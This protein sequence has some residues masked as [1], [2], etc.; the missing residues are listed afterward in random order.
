MKM[1]ERVGKIWDS[2]T[3]IFTRR[4]KMEEFTR[5]QVEE[6]VREAVE[7]TEKS[8]G[9][10][11]KRMKAENEDMQASMEAERVRLDAE[12]TR[13]AEER[14]ALEDRLAG[15]ERELAEKRAK[16]G[17]LSVREEIRHQ[18]DGKNPLPGRF[19]PVSEI[20]YT[21]DA[22]ALA[23]AV[24]EAIEKGRRE[25]EETLRE[26]GIAG[27]PETGGPVNPTNPASRGAGAARDQKA[28]AARE[29]LKDMARRGMIR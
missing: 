14:T 6:L 11:F 1:R 22:E 17:E 26:A 29:A 2:G 5:E 10:T 28:E 18:M 7:K 15:L 12:Q 9:G 23:S 16:V 8:F 4:K 27:N 13:F 3:F 24:S 25:F 19:I 20:V 21:E